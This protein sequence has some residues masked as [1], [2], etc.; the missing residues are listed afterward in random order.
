ME[1]LLN[2]IHIVSLVGPQGVGKTT[3]GLRLA[4]LLDN[5]HVEASDYAKRITGTD[6]RSELP[7]LTEQHTKQN[8]DWLGQAIEE[9]II[10]HDKKTI[11]LTGV[12]ERNVHLYLA[13]RGGRLAIFELE[14]P[15]EL[16]FQRL[17]RLGKVSNATEFIE[18]EIKEVKLGVYEVCKDALHRVPNATDVPAPKI[19]RAIEKTF[20]SQL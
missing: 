11:V 8:P 13:S 16:R 7:T 15:A 9:E 14:A 3:I 1:E 2:G 5:I 6:A 19:A 20:R 10:K 17:C 12:R 18:Q 4:L